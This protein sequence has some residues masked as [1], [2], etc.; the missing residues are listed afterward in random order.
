MNCNRGT[1]VGIALSIAT[2]VLCAVTPSQAQ[3]EIEEDRVSGSAG[4]TFLNERNARGM[5][6]EDQGLITQALL[7]INFEL[8]DNISLTSGVWTDIH[9]NN[10]GPGP[11]AAAVGAGIGDSNLE[12]F[13]EFDWWFGVNFE[14]A[15]LNVLV[16]YEEFLNP[17]D[18]FASQTGGFE[19]QHVQTVFTY[20]ELG[21][22]MFGLVDGVNLNPHL[23]LLFEIDGSVGPTAENGVYIEIGVAPSFIAIPDETN[24]VTLAFPITV[25]LGSDFYEDDETLGYV[26]VGTKA[27]MPLPQL[28]DW[29]DWSLSLGVNA[30]MANDDAV[31]NFNSGVAGQSDDTRVIGYLSIGVGF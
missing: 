20:D 10:D 26:A 6:L 18:D 15:K 29:G 23:R 3:A 24:P 17:A 13:Y 27:S 31:G 16:Y 30:I 14:V 5:V 11:S 8:T 28:S 1:T 2:G 7:G 9:S 21:N 4:V 19:S 25:G 22:N 12:E